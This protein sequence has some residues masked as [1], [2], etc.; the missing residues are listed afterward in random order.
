MTPRHHRVSVVVTTIQEEHSSF[1]RNCRLAAFSGCAETKAQ[2]ATNP[3]RE[4]AGRACGPVL[5][6]P[7]LRSLHQSQ[8]CSLHPPLPQPSKIR[9][10]NPGVKTKLSK[11]SREVG[12][13]RTWLM[14]ETCSKGI[15]KPSESV[16]KQVF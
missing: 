15:R 13:S 8:H 12:C 11:R 16:L 5:P 3:G 1:Q 7:R 9:E 14:K 2:N 4:P 10:W 6:Q